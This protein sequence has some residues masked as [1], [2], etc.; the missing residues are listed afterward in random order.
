MTI[1]WTDVRG[2][3]ATWTEKGAVADRLADGDPPWIQ[4][5]G[6]PNGGRSCSSPAF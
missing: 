1:G 2:V 4:R 3:M 6:A 5:P